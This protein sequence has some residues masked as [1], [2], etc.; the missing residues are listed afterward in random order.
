MWTTPLYEQTLEKV[1][2]I[3]L[4]ELSGSAIELLQVISMLNPEAIPEDMLVQC[5]LLNLDSSNQE[6]ESRI[7]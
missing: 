7:R 2:N 3:A 1:W 5:A 6:S 4:Q